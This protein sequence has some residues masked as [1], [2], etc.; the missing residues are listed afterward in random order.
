MIHRVP[1]PGRGRCSAV[2]SDGLVYAVAT[3]PQ[4]ADGVTAQTRNTLAALE[5]RLT[6]A[7]SGK[8]GLLQATVYLADIADK[9]AMDAVWIDWIG[10]EQNWPQRACVGAALEGDCL[11]EI[12]VTAKAL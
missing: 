6:E 11:V 7:G 4:T 3:D 1:I 10:P 5:R 12:V 9:A 8:A 2:V